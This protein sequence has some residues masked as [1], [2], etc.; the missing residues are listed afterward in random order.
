MKK[1]FT[2]LM[3]AM[4]GF[5]LTGCRQCIWDELDELDNRVTAL[6][7]IVKKTNSDIAAIQTILNAIQ[8]NV[9]VTNVITTPDGYTIQFS[10]GTSATISNGTDGADANTPVISVK[11]DTDGNYYWTINGEWLIVDGE[12]VRANGHDGQSGQDGQDGQDGED[13][14]DGQDAVAPQV[15]INEDTK[16]WEISTDGGVTWV[17]TGVIAEGQDGENGSVIVEGETLFQSI[18]YTNEDYVIFTLADGTVLKVARYDESAPMFIIVDAPE[19]IQMEYGTTVEFEVEAT[20]VVEHLINVPEGWHASYINNVLSITAPVKDLC[21][22]DKEGFIAITVVSDSGKMS[23]VKKN[24][25][26]GEWVASVELRTLTFE[27]ANAQ[28][29]PYELEYFN[30]KQ[31]TT[32]S[33]LIAEDQYGDYILG[34]G[35]WMGECIPTDDSHYSWYDEN[36]TFLAH[37]FPL[38]YDSYC[39]AGGGHAISNYVSSDYAEYGNYMYQLTAYDKDANGLVTSGGGHNGSDNFAVHYGYYDGSSWNQ[40]TE[41]D[42]PAIYFKDGEARVIDHL[43]VC[44]TTYEYY[45]LYEGNGLTAPMGEGDYVILE[46]IGH[47]EDG[48]TSKISIRVADYHDGVIDDWTKWDLTAL[49]EVVKVNFNIIGTNDNGYGFSQPAYFAYD[50]VAVQFPGETIFR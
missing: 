48:T 2:F 40:T 38:N 15:R 43:Y 3:I 12:R 4:V 47:K 24:V 18:D 30:N 26:A 50:D 1:I 16:E 19:L 28:F 13:G 49:G 42:L 11:Q 6:E 44:L 33:D 37:D 17:S 39:F 23:I 41:E 46:A 7:E 14:Q 8:N 34:Y 5:A 10:D 31:I 27:D 9:F 45:C 22:Y 35:T 32:W 29:T 21:H 36:N 25:M 20:N